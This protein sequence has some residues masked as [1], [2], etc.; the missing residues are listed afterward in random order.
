MAP[1][2]LPANIVEQGTAF[3]QA[4]V[5]WE[6]QLPSI[7]WNDL[8]ADIEAERLA[9]FSVDMI[10]G[11]CT[12]GA[13]ASPRVQAIVPAVAVTFEMPMQQECVTLYL[14][15]MP[16]LSMLLNLR[17][18]HLT[19]KQAQ[20]RPRRFPSCYISPSL[21]SIKLSVK[22]R[23]TPFTVQNCWHGRIFIVI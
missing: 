18:M 10:N 14:P 9:V 20:A 21:T 7:S 23:S 19:V 12:Q 13:L 4:L 22:T 17:A 1:S 5:E 3:L 2:T 6:R 8:R 16:I 11:F 15:R